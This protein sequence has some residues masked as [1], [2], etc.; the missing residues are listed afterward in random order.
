MASSSLG[1]IHRGNTVLLSPIEA[2]KESQRLRQN[3]MRLLGY[4]GF[5]LFPHNKIQISQDHCI[6]LS[7]C[8]DQDAGWSV[9]EENIQK[10]LGAD[11]WLEFVTED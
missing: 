9:A 11:V 1:K 2:L 4:D 8:D 3:R 6:D 7:N 5:F 10:L